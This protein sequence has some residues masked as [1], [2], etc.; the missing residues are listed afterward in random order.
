MSAQ[1]RQFI[2]ENNFGDI[3]PRRL[4]YDGII[5]S[6]GRSASQNLIS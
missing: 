5:F 3:G 6:V 2:Q 1:Y 4:K